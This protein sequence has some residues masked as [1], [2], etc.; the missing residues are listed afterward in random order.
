MGER[1]GL[2]SSMGTWEHGNIRTW[3]HG[4]SE[5]GLRRLTGI[6]Q[7]NWILMGLDFVAL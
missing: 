3:E 2:G 1:L 7:I 6:T 5:P 4:K